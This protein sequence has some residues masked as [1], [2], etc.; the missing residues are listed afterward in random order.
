MNHRVTV[1]VRK[2]EDWYVSVCVENNVA[3]QGKSVEEAVS[4]LR[5]ALELYYEDAP[6][7]LISDSPVFVT[8]MEVAV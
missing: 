8:S 3:S 2:E 1:I 4:N 6:E 5:E 7:E